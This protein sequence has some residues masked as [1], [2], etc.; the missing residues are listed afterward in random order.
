MDAKGPEE[1]KNDRKISPLFV[2]HS[3]RER[4]ANAAEP[5]LSPPASQSL[6]LLSRTCAYRAR[7]KHDL[8]TVYV[9]MHSLF[10]F[11]AG[12]C[13]FGSAPLQLRDFFFRSRHP[14]HAHLRISDHQIQLKSVCCV[15]SIRNS[16]SIFFLSINLFGLPELHMPM[17]FLA[18]IYTFTMRSRCVFFVRLSS[19]RSFS[20]E[21]RASEIRRCSERRPIVVCPDRGQRNGK[22]REKSTNRRN[23]KRKSFIVPKDKS[24]LPK[25]LSIIVRSSLIFLRFFASSVSRRSRRLLGRFEF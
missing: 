19:V 12:L 3:E 15:F 1:R 2:C 17:I 10:Y 11:C 22:K 23:L 9:Q 25:L 24:N 6:Y 20:H 13:L 18:N 4:I 5:T 14:I 7:S 21:R 16:Q 8:R